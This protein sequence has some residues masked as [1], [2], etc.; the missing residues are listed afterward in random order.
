VQKQQQQT[1]Q[2]QAKPVRVGGAVWPDNWVATEVSSQVINQ[3]GQVSPTQ[4][5]CAARFDNSQCQVQTAYSNA[6][7]YYDF[8]NQRERF[9]NSDGTVQVNL[10]G[11]TLMAMAVTPSNACQY[12]CPIPANSTLSN[13]LDYFLDPSATDMGQVT[14]QGQQVEEWTWK[15][16][17]PIVN[18]TMEYTNNYAVKQGD[19]GIWLPVAQDTYLT[20]LGQQI[21][22]EHTGWTNFNT[23][24]PPAAKFAITGISTCPQDPQGCQQQQQQ[25][26]SRRRLN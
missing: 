8:A 20:P 6:V 16:V 23:G 19:I 4:I 11:T 26:K 12:Y 22:V 21:G 1:K 2:Q 3:G 7:H 13:G 10:Y 25:Q 15:E 9:E 5:C 24:V 18:I 14:Y 17:I